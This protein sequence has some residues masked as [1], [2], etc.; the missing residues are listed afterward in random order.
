MSSDA[1]VHS[2]RSHMRNSERNIMQSPDRRSFLRKGAIGAGALLGTGLQRAQAAA[3]EDTGNSHLNRGD[4]AILRFLS[5]LEE[6]EADLWIQYAELGGATS[7]GLS[8]IDLMQNG[9]KINTGLAPN[10]VLALEQ[11]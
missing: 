3:F 8:P 2:E 4:V 5:A 1:V 6:V 9:Q 10:Y 11:L 7:Q